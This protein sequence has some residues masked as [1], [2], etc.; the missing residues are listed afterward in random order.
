MRTRTV[1][2]SAA[3]VLCTVLGSV[4]C[5]ASAD[6]TPSPGGSASAENGTSR[7]QTGG[8][9]PAVD[10]SKCA[11]SAKEMPEGCEI[12]MHVSDISEATP[13]TEAPSIR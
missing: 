1:A 12:D 11:T 7:S 5:S 13:A 8:T 4:A 3:L 6:G 2:A 10:P 9:E